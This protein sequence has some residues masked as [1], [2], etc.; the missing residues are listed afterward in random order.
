VTPELARADA[1]RADNSRAAGRPL[2][3]D[4]LPVALKD[5]IDVAGARTTVGSQVYADRVAERDATVTARLRAAGAVVLGKLHLHEFVYGVTSDNPWYGACRNPWDLDRIPGGSS[6]GSGA[7]VASDLC[8]AALGSDTGGSIRI[9]ASL[10][11]VTGLRP[12]LGAVSSRGAFPI[13]RSFDTV[14]PLARSAADVMAL[15]LQMAGYDPDDARALPGR[16]VE[17]ATAGAEGLRIGLPEGEW[18][19]GDLDPEIERAVRAAA[20]RLGDLGARVVEIEIPDAAVAAANDACTIITR[21]EAYAIHRRVYHEQPERLGDDTVR[22]LRLGELVTGAEFADA[23]QA[24]HEWRRTMAAVL[25]TVDLVLTP[26]CATTAPRRAD[27]ETI[28]TTARL[29]RLTHPFSV[30]GMPALSLPCGMTESGMPIG[31]QLAAAPWADAVALRAAIAFQAA[32]V[33]HRRRPPALFT[34]AG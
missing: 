2:P 27:S 11:G 19:F 20:E 25:G 6:G 32:S 18:F 9:P 5:N 1:Q 22:R 29:T 16:L 26:T 4:G 17:P 3:L 31:V 21:A 12:T 8:I 34:D 33:W 14:G 13:A 15:V 10:T 30:A 24:M 23:L 7:A 28:A